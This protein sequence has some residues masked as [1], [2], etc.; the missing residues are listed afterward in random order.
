[1][2]ISML[3]QMLFT[4]DCG[5]EVIIGDLEHAKIWMCPECR[6]STN[7]DREPRKSALMKDLDTARQV[8]L[9]AKERGQSI[10]RLG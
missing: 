3:D 6:K 7:L 4:L 9:Q 8:D 5:H 2:T 10:T 1:M